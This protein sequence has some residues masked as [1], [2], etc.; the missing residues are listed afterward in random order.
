MYVIIHNTNER[1]FIAYKSLGSTL[2]HN[3]M[4]TV[5]VHAV[6]ERRFPRAFFL[7]T[8]LQEAV[9]GRRSLVAVLQGLSALRPEQ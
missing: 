5:L 8:R 2:M 6:G 7:A 4:L 3:R 9:E 1:R